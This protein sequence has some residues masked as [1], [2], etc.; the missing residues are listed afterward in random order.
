MEK[1]DFSEYS[2]LFKRLLTAAIKHGDKYEY[3]YLH[4]QANMFWVNI[5]LM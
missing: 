1:C 2:V 3:I 5:V 4:V